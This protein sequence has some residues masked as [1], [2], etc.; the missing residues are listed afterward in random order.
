MNASHT[1]DSA[2]EKALE[3]AIKILSE[4][5]ETV[6]I[7]TSNYVGGDKDTEFRYAGYGNWF[8]RFG[9]LVEWVE[10]Q[11]HRAR[12]EEEDDYKDKEDDE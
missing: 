5:F 2:E 10:K 9:Q 7:F 6:S 1:P 3:Q 4:H 12:L 11:H 8:A